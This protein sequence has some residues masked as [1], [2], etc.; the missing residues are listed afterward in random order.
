MSDEDMKKPSRLEIINTTGKCTALI[1]WASLTLDF[2]GEPIPAGYK[3]EYLYG[4]DF[5]VCSCPHNFKPY[6]EFGF[7]P[8]DE[9]ENPT[10]EVGA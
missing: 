8:N 3:E 5:A 7:L 9:K 1:R 10:K 4:T 6:C 2:I